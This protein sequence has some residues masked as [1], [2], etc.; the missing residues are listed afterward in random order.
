MTM[1]QEI[2]LGRSISEFVIRFIP[3]EGFDLSSELTFLVFQKSFHLVVARNGP[4]IDA[5][6]SC[7][8]TIEIQFRIDSGVFAPLF[9]QGL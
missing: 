7:R 5:H 8:C 4:I 9:L 3:A 2:L 6:P 1:P